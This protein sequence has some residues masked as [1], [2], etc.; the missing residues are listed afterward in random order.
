MTEGVYVL[1][2]QVSRCINVNVGA[3]GRVKFQK[4]LYAYVGSAQNNLEKRVG[5]HFKR[6]KRKFWHIDYLLS[7]GVAKILKIFYKKAEKSEECEIAKEINRRS[8]SVKG[9]GSS[10]CK[11][12]GHL[13]KIDDY[14]FLKEFMHEMHL[15]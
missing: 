3:L 7:C 1:V 9:F 4:G 2:I 11:C 13:F 14:G 15:Y 8:I 12:K 10:D 6:A 5:R